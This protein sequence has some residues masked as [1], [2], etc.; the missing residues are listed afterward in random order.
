MSFACLAQNHRHRTIHNHIVDGI[1]SRAPYGFFVPPIIKE[2]DRLARSWVDDLTSVAKYDFPQGQIVIVAERGNRE[3][4]EMK[5]RERNC[6]IPTKIKD[7]S[8]AGWS[9]EKIF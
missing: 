4:L 7:C 1:G 9:F 6:G 8:S 3:D 2:E 5:L